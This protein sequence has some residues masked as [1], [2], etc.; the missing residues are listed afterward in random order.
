MSLNQA[1]QTA[2]AYRQGMIDNNQNAAMNAPMLAIQA[3]NVGL[4]AQAQSQQA[5]FQMQSMILGTQLQIE[6]TKNKQA[7][8]VMEFDFAQ[9]KFAADQEQA[10]MDFDLRKQSLAANLDFNAIKTQQAKNEMATARNNQLADTFIGAQFARGMTEEQL[11]TGANPEGLA[12]FVQTYPE[13]GAVLGA[14]LNTARTAAKS[15]L[16]GQIADLSLARDKA[17]FDAKATP[18]ARVLAE[19]YFGKQIQPLEDR[20]AA[21]E[22]RPAQNLSDTGIMSKLAAFKGTNTLDVKTRLDLLDAARKEEEIGTPEA[23]TRA[24]ALRQEASGAMPGEP[25]QTPEDAAAEARKA[26]LAKAKDA[27]TALAITN[28][29]RTSPEVL[30]TNRATATATK[31]VDDWEKVTGTVAA[32]SL[33]S[34]LTTS[35]DPQKIAEAQKLR[36]ILDAAIQATRA[37]VQGRAAV[38]MRSPTASESAAAA[39]PG[40]A[41]GTGAIP[42]G[43]FAAGTRVR[44]LTQSEMDSLTN[45]PSFENVKRI[46]SRLEVK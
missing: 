12:E 9:R 11:L 16:A 24:E 3:L 8:Q 31:G 37:G 21:I 19:Q 14:R 2:V 36:D 27:Q 22:G 6:E 42:G 39:R 35:A 25:G 45:D 10:K 32:N 34:I 44:T 46:L 17:I 28:S 15:N 38:A 43:G 18:G 41:A 29:R 7:M 33:D 4:Q 20:L 26:L 23:L 30:A 13:A 1:F 40:T 5:Q